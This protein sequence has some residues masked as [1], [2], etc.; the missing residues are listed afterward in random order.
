[1]NACY[2]SSEVGLLDSVV[3]QHPTAQHALPAPPVGRLQYSRP[4]QPRV[5]A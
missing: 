4:P 5:A 3:Q 1:M 2:A